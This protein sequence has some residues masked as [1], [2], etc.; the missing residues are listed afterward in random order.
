MMLIGA[1]I[2]GTPGGGCASTFHIALQGASG[3]ESPY[4][5]TGSTT[6]GG[7]QRQDE[8]ALWHC[9]TVGLRRS[10]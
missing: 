5:A 2:V 6:S 3:A 8:V 9:G 7:T 10:A 4:C 1:P